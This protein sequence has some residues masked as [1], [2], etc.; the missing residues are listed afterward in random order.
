[1]H[2]EHLKRIPDLDKTYKK[3][4]GSKAGLKDVVGIYFFSIRLPLIIDCLKSVS[5]EYSIILNER[6]TSKLSQI[7]ANFSKFEELVELTIDLKAVDNHEYIVKAEFAPQ[8]KELGKTKSG[9]LSKMESLRNE[10][11]DEINLEEFKLK[12]N[13]AANHGHHFRIT[14]KEET[15][16][17]GRSEFI[18]LET[19][20]DGVRFTTRPMMKL[21]TQLK[22]VTQQYNEIQHEVVNKI[23]EL[24]RS[25]TPLIEEASVILAEL[26]V[27]ISLGVVA[28]SAPGSFVKPRILSEGSGVLEF[29]EARHPCMEAQDGFSFIPNDIVLERNLFLFC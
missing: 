12:L 21:S 10:V 18:S 27:L 15:K 17:R 11:A 29:R 14:R 24:T 1:L 8:L 7:S 13:H 22:E 3:L 5:S 16:I 19:R 2:D 26:D 25:Y 6:F 28:A 4:Q 23:I 20:K 9:I